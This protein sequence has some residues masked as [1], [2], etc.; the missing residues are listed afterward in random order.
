MKKVFI[1][2]VALLMCFPAISS[3]LTFTI[4]TE[5]DTGNT[6]NFGSI[7]VTDLGDNLQFEVDLN[8]AELG[9]GADL[10]YLHFNIVSGFTNV[11]ASGGGVVDSSFEYS[12][13]SSSPTTGYKA[14]GDGFY[15]VK[16][17][18]GSGATPQVTQTTF[19][20]S[21]NNSLDIGNIVSLSEGGAKGSF[22]MAIH[23]QDT[24]WLG[25]DAT[26]EWAGASIPDPA[27]VFLLGSASLIGFAGARR[28][29]KKVR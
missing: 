2:F 28:K 24:T 21:A 20:V 16:V 10:E 22:Y 1:F 11:T 29:F 6:V 18:F 5:F 26:S 19:T 23:A 7:E 17:Y 15:D 8:L 14:D 13:T 12:N 9:S 3:A 27:A 4:D 25:D